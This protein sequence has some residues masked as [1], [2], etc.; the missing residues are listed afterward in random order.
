MN[1]PGHAYLRSLSGEAV[2][3]ILESDNGDKLRCCIARFLKGDVGSGGYGTSDPAVMQAVV[4]AVPSIASSTRLILYELF[5]F[6][7]GF[8]FVRF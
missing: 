2:K 6:M 3:V 5:D 1:A 7:I 8:L 4:R